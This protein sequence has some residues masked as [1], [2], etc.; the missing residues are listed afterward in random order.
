M[1]QDYQRDSYFYHVTAIENLAGINR[2]GIQPQSSSREGLEADLPEVAADTGIEFQIDRQQC[3]FFYPLLQPALESARFSKEM[4]I[5]SA[6][7]G[8]LKCTPEGIAV[9]DGTRIDSNIYVGDFQLISDAIDLQFM[10]E[11]DDAIVSDSYEDALRRYAS[12]FRYLDSFEAI[13]QLTDEFHFPELVVEG[14]V[15]PET[16][17]EW[18]F[19]KNIRTE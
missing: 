14:G 2:Q 7:L 5:D 6:H 13:D 16:V 9:V 3:V 10:D 15:S 17:I 18:L 12:S 19:V 4:C 11:P 1:G 8:G